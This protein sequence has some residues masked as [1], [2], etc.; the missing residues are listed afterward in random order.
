MNSYIKYII[1]AFDFNS[2]DKKKKVINA[3][4][5]IKDILQKIQ[6]RRELSDAEYS[7]LETYIGIYEVS[8][9][10]EL[11]QVIKYFINL[12]GNDCN[13]NWINVSKVRSMDSL[14]NESEFTGDISEWDVS[15]VKYMDHMFYNSVFNGDISNWNVGN[16]QDMTAMFQFSKFNSDISK[17]D[18]SNVTNMQYMFYGTEFNKDISNWDV[19]NVTDMSRMFSNSQFNQD[20]GKWDVSNVTDMDGMFFF[21]NFNQDISKW[22]VSKVKNIQNIDMFS[23]CPIRDWYKP[24]ITIAL[25][26]SFDFDTINTQKKIINGTDILYN[27]IIPRIEKR[28]LTQDDYNIL[29]QYTGI[30]K[31][32]DKDDLKDLIAYFM[33]LFGNDVNLNWID[34]SDITDMSYLFEESEFNGDISKWNV[35]NVTNMAGMFWNTKFNG[36]ISNWD[37]SKV[38]NMNHMFSMSIF[39]GDI[40]RWNVSHVKDVRR[41]FSAAVE[42]NQDISNWDLRSVTAAR[43]MFWNCNIKDVYKPAV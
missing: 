16:V 21:S 17:W 33:N 34:V 8:D 2:V 15:S 20:I 39:N 10:D 23:K 30:Y 24:N 18:V 28:E 7:I 11:K 25:R 29:I 13:L 22:D 5:I 37:V 36:D 12:F 40:S 35:S 42:F 43:N 31:V 27:Y 14:F 38:E 4:D 9:N 3:A 41:M 26:E 6:E 32:K 19:S 1:E